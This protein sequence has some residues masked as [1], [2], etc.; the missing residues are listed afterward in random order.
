MRVIVVIPT[1]N[2]QQH[3]LRAIDN[4]VGLTVAV[5]EILVVA[6]GSTDGSA[7]AIHDRSGSRVIEVRKEN[8]GVSARA[9]AASAKPAANMD[10][11]PGQRRPLAA[12]E[13]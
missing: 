11:L 13:T 4:V 6:D 9:T 12:H 5:D 7:E 2:R 3:S 8:A 10:F 1:Y